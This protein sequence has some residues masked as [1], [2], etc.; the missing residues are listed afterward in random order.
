MAGNGGVPE[1]TTHAANRRRTLRS[2]EVVFPERVSSGSDPSANA[3]VRQASATASALTITHCW[4]IAA[5]SRLL[6]SPVSTSCHLD[7]P[8]H[9]YH[10]KLTLSS[11]P[12]SVVAVTHA[13]KYRTP[14]QAST[15]PELTHISV[16]RSNKPQPP[17]QDPYPQPQTGVYSERASS[18]VA[19]EREAGTQP[20]ARLREIT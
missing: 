15:R 11:R 12:F 14:T 10:H 17:P 3:S 2:F 5:R 4:S 7:Y 8:T 19:T 20:S 16:F 13:P 6:L 1:S 18:H 9:F